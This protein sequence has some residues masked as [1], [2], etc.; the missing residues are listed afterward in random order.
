MTIYKG[1][2]EALHC[3]IPTISKKIG[4]MVEVLPDDWLVHEDTIAEWRSRIEQVSA[5]PS[6][7]ERCARLVE[8]FESEREVEKIL[9]LVRD[10]IK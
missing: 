1:L 7:H 9:S 4:G 2:F 5:A 3:G 10:L 8:A 6:A